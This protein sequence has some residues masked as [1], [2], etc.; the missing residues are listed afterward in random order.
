MTMKWKRVEVEVLNIF[1]LIWYVF[2]VLEW[3]TLTA[4]LEVLTV[5]CWTECIWCIWCTDSYQMVLSWYFR[6]I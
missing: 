2:R 5:T 6:V 4:D 1:E 3:N